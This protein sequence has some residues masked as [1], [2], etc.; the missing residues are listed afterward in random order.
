MIWIRRDN[1]LIRLVV[2]D[3]DELCFPTQAMKMTVKVASE[4]CLLE[5]Y[6]LRRYCPESGLFSRPICQKWRVQDHKP[7]MRPAFLL[8]IQQHGHLEGR[9]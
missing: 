7:R 6:F 1:F 4:V 9:V 2:L 3:Y 8:A 5:L